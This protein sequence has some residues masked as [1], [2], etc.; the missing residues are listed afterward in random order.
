[1]KELVNR[2]GRMTSLVIAEIIGKSHGHLMRD[3]RKMEK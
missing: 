2:N 1:M 3:I